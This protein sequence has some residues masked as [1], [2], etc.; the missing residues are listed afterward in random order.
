M[1]NNRIA[2]GLAK[3]LG[4]DTTGMSPKEVWDVLKQNGISDLG[5]SPAKQY[6]NKSIKELKHNQ[7]VSIGKDASVDYIVKRSDLFHFYGIYGFAEATIYETKDGTS[8]IYGD[9]DPALQKVQHQQ[10]IDCFYKIPIT[11][12]K[13]AQKQICFVDYD[14]PDNEKYSQENGSLAR[15]LAN[16]WYNQITVFKNNGYSDSKLVDLFVHEIAHKIDVEFAE[17][18]KR[19]SS[20]NL[21]KQ[22]QIEDFKMYSVDSPTK[23]GLTND[24]ED[25]AESVKVYNRNKSYME[26]LFSNRTKLIKQILGEK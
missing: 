20:S 13:F 24:R 12:R 26:R 11:I 15:C 1:A 14:N 10:A 25:F 2:Y 17:N 4:I 23:Y 6:E 19:F 21:Y 3:G 9:N 8:F 16:S 7:V 22:A 18:Q 5:P